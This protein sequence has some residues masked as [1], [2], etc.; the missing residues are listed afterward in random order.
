VQIPIACSL[1]ADETHGR[2]EEWRTFLGSHVDSVVVGSGTVR[3]RLAQSDRALGFAADLA[4]R[5]KECCAFFAFSLD[6]DDSR[7]WWLHIGVPPDA[8]TI[9]DDLMGL[10]PPRLGP[11]AIS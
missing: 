1:T 5:E 4:E 3:L 11:A 7:R 2:V 9:L 10:L 8:I 6:L